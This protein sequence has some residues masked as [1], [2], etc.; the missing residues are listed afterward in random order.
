MY[1]KKTTPVRKAVDWLIAKGKI[2]QDKYLLNPDMSANVYKKT[3]AELKAKQSRLVQEQSQANTENN[4][5]FDR[6]N[7]LLPKL[8]DLRKAFEEMDIMAKQQ[9]VNTVFDHSLSHDGEIYR[10]PFI[11]ELFSHNSLKLKEKGLLKIDS[12]LKKIGETPLRREKESWLQ[13]FKKLLDIF[14]A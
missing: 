11:H 12:P 6:L 8:K 13:N 14:A 9:F 10:T 3:I 1:N 4:V 7:I 2:S 5:Y